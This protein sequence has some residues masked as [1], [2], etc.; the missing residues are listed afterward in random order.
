M[1]L[2][3]TIPRSW[4]TCSSNWAS[5]GTRVKPFKE[6]FDYLNYVQLVLGKKQKQILFIFIYFIL[7]YFIYFILFM[8]HLGNSVG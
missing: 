8:G 2:K 4:V 7:F 5:P 6:A 1:G 3:L